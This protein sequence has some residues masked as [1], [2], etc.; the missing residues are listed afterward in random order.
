M[1]DTVDLKIKCILQAKEKLVYSE[2]E[3]YNLGHENYGKTILDR[4]SWEEHVS[5]ESTGGGNWEFEV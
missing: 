4:G 5:T 2:I 3:N 1:L